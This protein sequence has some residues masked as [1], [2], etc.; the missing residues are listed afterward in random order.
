MTVAPMLSKPTPPRFGSSH[1]VLTQTTTSRI[2]PPQPEYRCTDA[3]R[4][5]AITAPTPFPLRAREG[6]RPDSSQPRAM[7]WESS[8]L[9]WRALK[10]RLNPAIQPPLQGSAV[11][12]LLSQGVALGY[13][14]SGRWPLRKKHKQTAL[15]TARHKPPHLVAY[16]LG[17]VHTLSGTTPTNRTLL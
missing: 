12:V 3:H 9:S 17:P 5:Q 15:T 7:P 16:K 13:H 2:I 8:R 10:E 1:H 6:Q 11:L 4:A 14:G